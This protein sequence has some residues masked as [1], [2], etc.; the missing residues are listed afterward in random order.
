MWTRSRFNNEYVPGL[1]TVMV[2]SYQTRRATSEWMNMC[3]VKNSEKAYEEDANRS[4]LGSDRK[5]VV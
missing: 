2:D 1:F 4:G 5:S 3:G